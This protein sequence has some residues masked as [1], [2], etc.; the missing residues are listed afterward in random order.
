ML[1]LSRKLGESICIGANIAV[2]I[3]QI[4]DGR[5]KI[6]IEAPKSIPI[7]RRELTSSSQTRNGSTITAPRNSTNGDGKRDSAN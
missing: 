2:V 5:V 6:G 4:D 7:F 1:V 3:T